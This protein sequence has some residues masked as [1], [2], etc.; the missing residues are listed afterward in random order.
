MDFGA[1]YANYSADL[2]RTIPVNGRFTDRQKAV[3]NAV[4]NIMKEATAM[5]TPGTLLKEYEAEVGKLMSSALV[6]L[7]LLTKDEVSGNQ[8]AY[9]RY[10]MHGT[11]HFLGL[12]TH[13]VG[14]RHAPIAEGMV[15]T[16][17]PGIYI[18][19]EG[20][21]VRIENDVLVASG[22]PKDLMA[23]IPKEVDEIEEVMNRSQIEA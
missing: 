6:D 11:S 20:L 15:F 8:K 4:L 2:S 17:E 7:G 19:E 5:L 10:Y 21:G 9:K 23:H 13:D 3:Y 1:E 16:V 18:K 12:D 22:T 14:N